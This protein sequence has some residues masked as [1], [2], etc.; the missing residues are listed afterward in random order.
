VSEPLPGYPPTYFETLAAVED[1]HWWHRGMRAVAASLLGER[2]ARGG[3]LLDA[4]CG[5][6]GF[7]A[8][9]A[10]RGFGPLSGIDVAPQALDAARR[11][12]PGADLRQAPLWELP[13]DGGAFAVVVCNDVL[14]HV[15]EQHEA[16]SVQELRRVLARDGALLLRT[17]GGLRARRERADWRV[18]D[19][20][21]LRRLLRENGLRCERIAYVNG[22]GSLAALARG[23]VPH[24][25]TGRSHGIPEL[26]R[27]R[28]RVRYGLV[29]AEAAALR[30]LPAALPYGHTLV[31]LA[32]RD[33]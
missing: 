7:L 25:P 16:R 1:G 15:E 24:A 28:A 11:R 27:G 5:T 9:A 2:L 8:W 10:Q 20:R 12:L 14:Q 33:E 17:N 3:A 23:R 6:G 30:R 32:V 29:R 13:F 4:G 21:G 22:I 31:A 26:P 19:R 18:Y